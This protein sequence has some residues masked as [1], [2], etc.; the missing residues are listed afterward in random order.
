M[1]VHIVVW[2]LKE[3]DAQDKK[4]K[5]GTKI[6]QMLEDLKNTIPQIVKLEC[7][8]NF[9]NSDSAFDISLYSMF[10]SIE[11]LQIYQN[12]PDHKMVAEFISKS[13]AKRAVVDYE[14]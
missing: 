7:G 3:I 10:D 6:K 4:E 5:I 8:L 11:N 14:L 1:I 9:N 13:V 12:H 2:K